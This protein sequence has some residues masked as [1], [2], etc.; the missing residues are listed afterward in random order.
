MASPKVLWR[1]EART[2][3]LGLLC[4]SCLYDSDGL[5]NMWPNFDLT[6]AQPSVGS[7]T[8]RKSNHSR[9]IYTEGMPVDHTATEYRM[10]FLVFFAP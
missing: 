6:S 10:S 2:N 4:L 9:V 1:D 3:V 8:C 7:R 5:N